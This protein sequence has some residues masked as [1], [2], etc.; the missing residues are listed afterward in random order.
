MPN[1]CSNA[2]VVKGPKKDLDA[3]KATLNQKDVDG[4][5]VPFSF[6]QT[7]PPPANLF[8]GNLGDAERKECEAKGIPNWYD[9]QSANWGVKWDCCEANVSI[10]PKSVKVWFDTPW[11]PPL[12][13]FSNFA[14]KF[15]NLTAELAYNECGMAYYGVAEASEGTVSDNGGDKYEDG[16]TDE[17]G[18]PKGALKKHVNKYGLGMGG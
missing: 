17:D 6:A 18:N 7:V 14:A 2:L 10:A 11:A 9:W 1:W 12:A 4:I 5:E 3:F 15:P 8:R 13:W 16:D